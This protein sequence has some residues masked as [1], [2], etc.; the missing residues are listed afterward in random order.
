ML[1]TYED[2][3]SHLK[4][5]GFMPL[6]N[7]KAGFASLSSLT[8]EGTWHSGQAND[9]WIWRRLVAEEKL[10]AY[11]KFF[12]KK[13]S[14][15]TLEWFPYFLTVRRGSTSVEELYEMGKVSQA[16]KCIYDLFEGP[17]EIPAHDIKPLLERDM[18]K[19]ELDNAITELQMG[20]FLTASGVARKTNAQGEPYGWPSV[21]LMKVEEWVGEEI[22]TKAAGLDPI[23]ARAHIIV[24]ARDLSPEVAEKQ[25]VKFLGL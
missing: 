15:I 4:S 21:C 1:N 25:L 20:M 23:L 14:F 17:K 16:A 10:A 18:G 9:P 24:K 5:V 19:T 11:G 7:N 22:M 8:E 12:D 6:S 3:R 13:P 2:F